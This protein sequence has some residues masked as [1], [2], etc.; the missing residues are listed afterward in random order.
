M[1]GGI[2]YSSAKVDPI[3]EKKKYPVHFKQDLVTEIEKREQSLI[4][5]WTNQK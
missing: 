2:R 5:Y 1:T 4:E 3:V